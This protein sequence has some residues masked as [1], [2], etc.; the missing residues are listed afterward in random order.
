MVEGN[1]TP[2]LPATVP[3]T[4]PPVAPAPPPPPA[5]VAAA[6]IPWPPLLPLPFRT[7]PP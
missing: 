3:T 2:P 5:P 4:F 7:T 6:V 1:P